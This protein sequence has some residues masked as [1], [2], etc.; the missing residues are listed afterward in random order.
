MT[1]LEKMQKTTKAQQERSLLFQL[2]LHWDKGLTEWRQQ[3]KETLSKRSTGLSREINTA[4]SSGRMMGWQ[5]PGS[6]L[7]TQQDL[8]F[9]SSS[10]T[11][12][13]KT[14][15]SDYQLLISGWLK[16]F[17]TC[18]SVTPL[19]YL[20]ERQTKRPQESRYLLMSQPSTTHY[21]SLNPSLAQSRDSRLYFC[22]PY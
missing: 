4:P 19:W 17:G 12:T 11:L 22:P 3:R 1:R 5:H 9:A 7:G 10:C 21:L 18:S 2:M 6:L 20:K 15:G 13:G 16:P 14:S 8:N